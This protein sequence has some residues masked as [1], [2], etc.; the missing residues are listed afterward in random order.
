MTARRTG[1]TRRQW[2]AGGAA[3]GVSL[4]LG[5]C[6]RTARGDDRR[7]KRGLVIGPGSTRAS[8]DAPMRFHLSLLDLDED[9][10]G[11]DPLAPRHMGLEF[12]AHGMVPDPTDPSRLVLFEKRGKGACVADLRSLAVTRPITTADEREFYGHGAFSPDGR[13]LYAT[14]TVVGDDYRGVVVVRDGKSLAELG[15][16][17]SHGSAPHDL[18]LCEDGELLAITNGGG[19]REG[20]AAPSVTFVESSSGRLVEKLEVEEPAWNAGHVA[21]S[22]RSELALVSAGRPWLGKEALGGV[23]LRTAGGSL[24]AMKTP[25]ALVARLFGEALSVVI[26]EEARS[27][28]ATHPAAHLVTVW[29]LAEA[30]LRG[31]YDLA[32]PRGIARTLDGA[33]IQVSQGV[34]GRLVRFD[35]RTLAPAP[36]AARAFGANGSHLLVHDLAPVAS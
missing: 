21:L 7:G 27:V 16:L 26:D 30:S 19:E 6:A 13:L 8:S 28:W 15:I 23:S 11:A 14:E 18:H 33:Q 32:W 9:A 29:D 3:L 12:M 35:P 25:P 34:D 22:S 5:S 10:A 20:G 4:A 1:S 31:S 2:L 17:E 36:D 24:R